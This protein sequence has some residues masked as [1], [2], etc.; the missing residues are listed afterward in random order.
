MEYEFEI[1]EPEEE[2]EYVPTPQMLIAST[3]SNQL[4]ATIYFMANTALQIRSG[5]AKSA[6]GKIRLQYVADTPSGA[7]TASETLRKIV[8]TFTN[9]QG[10]A[11]NF[12]FHGQKT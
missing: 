3:K 8:F 4:K 5:I 12:E 6:M 7:Y 10:M 2:L 1:Q 11:S 9:P